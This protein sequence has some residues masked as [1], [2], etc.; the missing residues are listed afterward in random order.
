MNHTASCLS[1]VPGFLLVLQNCLSIYFK[2]EACHILLAFIYSKINDSGMKSADQK[3]I[4]FKYSL[5]WECVL[6]RTRIV[7]N[8][9]QKTNCYPLPDQIIASMKTQFQHG[10][11]EHILLSLSYERGKEK[12]HTRDTIGR[13]HRHSML[14]TLWVPNCTLL[15]WQVIMTRWKHI[16]ICYL[17][18]IIRYFLCKIIY[19]NGP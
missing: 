18:E 1:R 19:V 6:L 12:Q 5:I 3:K 10:K 14:D 7:A 4:L 11:M 8:Q 13:L 2:P 15:S 17:E 16:Y 9:K